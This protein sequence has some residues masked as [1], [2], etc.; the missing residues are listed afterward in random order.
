[1]AFTCP[2]HLRNDWNEFRKMCVRLKVEGTQIADFNNVRYN[3]LK[4]TFKPFLADGW[5]D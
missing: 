1:M 5:D 4:E 2:P 3:Q